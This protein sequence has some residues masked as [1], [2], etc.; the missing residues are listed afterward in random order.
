MEF[1]LNTSL[2]ITFEK[3]DELLE[4]SRFTKVKI[5]LL[6]TGK[7]LNNSVF[8]KE[9][10]EESLPSLSNIPI[11]GYITSDN[12]NQNDFNGHEERLVI[13]KD[14]VKIEY[15]GRVY[16]VIPETNN[17]EF[18]SK[19]GED[20]I[21]R[22]Y[23]T[24]EGLLYNKFPEAVDILERDG[25]KG[26]SMELD[27]SSI[28]GK[29]TKDG[30]YH[31]S[32]FK[33]EAACILGEGITPAMT[34]SLVEK[35]SVSNI[36]EQLKD[37]LQ[38]FNKNFSVASSDD[39]GSNLQGGE[40]MDE[41]LELLN[42]YSSLGEEVLEGIKTKL[43]EYS[44]EDLEAKLTQLSEANSDS[45]DEGHD[46]VD[47]QFTEG[48]G[49]QGEQ[50]DAEGGDAPTDYALTG[51]QFA[52]ELRNQLGKE[53]YTDDWGWESRK[54]WYVDYDDNRV[55]AEDS[56]DSFRLVG[57]DYSVNGDIV[58]VDFE[59]KKPVKVV[60]QD[61][62]GDSPVEFSIASSDRL[63]FEVNRTKETTKT[64]TEKQFSDTQSTID[65]M[66][67]KIDSLTEFKQEKER[68]EKLDVIKQF[69]SIDNEE[70]KEYVDNIDKY[71]KEELELRLFAEV[72]KGKLQFT[73]NNKKKDKN[74]ITSFT[75][76]HSKPD[77]NQPSWVELVDQYK[78]KQN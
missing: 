11:V 63:D 7:N 2:P 13:D 43:E 70:V 26:Q 30:L 35:F 74:I 27:P 42:K 71:T 48:E 56:Q 12:A 61:I 4:D 22:E 66:Q 65:D 55:Y 25:T 67:R 32:T 77:P 14:G 53:K 19:V 54:Y 18:E 31:F 41:K 40:T 45:K 6:H 50:G 3:Q 24:C 46:G 39:E 20:G 16:G 76:V 9:V 49:N 51:K 37:M 72:G 38:E 59:S 44:L 23:L 64:E 52:K 36:Q 21:E 73:K 8:E 28:D 10:V 68:E 15:I 57:L 34:G 33:F 69:T 60:F 29:F 78:S 75:D 58:A 62:E 17:A 1:T 5:W 47:D